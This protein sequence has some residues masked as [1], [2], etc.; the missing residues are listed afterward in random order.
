MEIYPHKQ[1]GVKKATSR[2]QKIPQRL[3]VFIKKAYLCTRFR[4][5]SSVV[6]RILGKDEVPSSTLGSS[7]ETMAEITSDRL[8]PLSFLSK[9][10]KEEYYIVCSQSILMPIAMR[11]RPPTSSALDLNRS[12]AFLPK[13]TPAMENIIVVIPIII[14]GIHIDISRKANETPTARASILVAIAR[15][16]ICQKPKPWATPSS[17][18]EKDSLTILAPMRVSNNHATQ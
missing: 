11:T 13:S 8:S 10:A 15:V 14:I 17:S 7:S 5:Y 9:Q 2:K 1:S 3:G 12:P 16:S 4:C 6:E 18:F